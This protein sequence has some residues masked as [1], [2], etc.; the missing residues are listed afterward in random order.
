MKKYISAIILSTLLVCIIAGCAAKS[1]EEIKDSTA[2]ATTTTTA[3]KENAAVDVEMRVASLKG[4]T[5]MGIVN[6]MYDDSLG[7]YKDKTEFSILTAADEIV[8]AIVKKEVDIALV[9]ANVAAILYKKTEQQIKVIDINTLGVLYIVDRDGSVKSISDLEGKDLYMTGKGTT[10]DY[11][12]QYL[13]SKCGVD[14]SKVNITYCSEAAEVITQMEN[15][16]SAVGLLPQ[17][18]VTTAIMK[19]ENLKIALDLTE[20]WD[21]VSNGSQLVTGVT[22]VR[23]EF[24]ENKPE[25]VEAFMNA[26]KKSV[27]F[28]KNDLETTAQRIEEKGI[29]KAGVVMKAYDMCHITCITGNEMQKALSGYIQALLDID[30]STV[31]GSLPDNSFYYINE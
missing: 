3:S 9:P 17:P 27:E 23:K 26:H 22:I 29:V 4:A 7:N 5:T 11:A 31:G 16:K 18:F 15:N 10:P 24:L 20:E 28:S 2:S 6:M 25:A 8:S 21:K 13:M 1:S 30:A 19:D 12:L 14:S